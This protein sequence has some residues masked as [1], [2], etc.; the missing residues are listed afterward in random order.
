MNVI[1]EKTWL[2][3]TRCSLILIFEES[4]QLRMQLLHISHSHFRIFK[5]LILV[6][7]SALL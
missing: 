3:Y 4:I 1:T 5:A 6:F 7:D 2:L